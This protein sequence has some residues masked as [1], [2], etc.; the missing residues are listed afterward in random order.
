MNKIYGSTEYIE[1][2]D[3]KVGVLK[4]S[5]ISQWD[6]ITETI[7]FRTQEKTLGG[8]TITISYSLEKCIYVSEDKTHTKWE[9]VEDITKD[10][11]DILI[12]EGNV[13]KKT[14]NNN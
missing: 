6:F 12:K 7:C 5:V 9:K 8:G 4:L 1:K 10:I 3:L 14:L 13:L 2:S 11:K